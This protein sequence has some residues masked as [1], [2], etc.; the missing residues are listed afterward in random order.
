MSASPTDERGGEDEDRVAQPDSAE[1]RVAQPHS[2]EVVD[3]IEQSFSQLFGVVK[4][5]MREAAATLG[6]DVQPAAWVVL[7][8]VLRNA[9][10]QAGA[11]AAGTGMDKSAVS[12]QLKDLR[13]RGLVDAE[14]SATDARSVL[15][16]PTPEA[17]RRVGLVRDEWSRRFRGILGTWSDDELS[18]FAVLLERFAAAE[19]W[20][21]PRP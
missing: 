3:S 9:P 10:T 19:P 18:T 1:G 17:L 5:A 12:R 20:L 15:I 6:P 8:W 14:Q 11:I 13:E 4:A 16:S 2:G 7:R 21:R